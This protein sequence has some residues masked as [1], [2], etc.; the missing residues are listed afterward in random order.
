M[1]SI[2]GTCFLGDVY[3]YF[4]AYI[5]FLGLFYGTLAITIMFGLASRYLVEKPAN[6]L[7]RYFPYEPVKSRE[8]TL[9]KSPQ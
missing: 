1:R 8:T 5:G 6:G 9:V 3:Y 4:E 2:C 7:K